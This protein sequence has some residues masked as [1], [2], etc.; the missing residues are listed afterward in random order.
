M[1][2]LSNI[3]YIV[4]GF[5]A[6]YLANKEVVQKKG[7]SIRQKVETTLKRPK[8]SIQPG[9]YRINDPEKIRERDN[10]DKDSEEGMKRILKRI[11]KVPAGQMNH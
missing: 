6:G 9:A 5:I 7:S 4:I 11:F 1:E 3:I 2:T 8:Q 10:P